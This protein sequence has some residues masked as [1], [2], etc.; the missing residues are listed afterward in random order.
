VD[1]VPGH[2]NV[3]D[4]V[5]HLRFWSDRARSRHADFIFASPVEHSFAD[6][7]GLATGDPTVDLATLVDRIVGTGHR[8]LVADV[9]SADVA[10]LGFHVVRAIVPGYHRLCMGHVLRSLG[11]RRLWEIPQRLGYEGISRAAGGDNPLPHPFP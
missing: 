10:Q 6:V 9:T 11:G 1:F 7:R 4:Q 5:S 3:V 8:V 2:R